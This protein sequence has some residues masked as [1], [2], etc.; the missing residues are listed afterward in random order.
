MNLQEEVIREKLNTCYSNVFEDELVDEFVREGLIDK[1]KEGQLMIDIDQEMTHLPLILDGIIK[2]IRKDKHGD[3]IVLYFLEPGDTCAISFV[4]C[5]NR[6]KSI[7]K[8]IVEKDAELILLPVNKMDEW[9]AR[10]KSWR[11]YI[12]DSYHFR[13]LEMVDS[14][15]CLA[16][17]KLDERLLKYLADKVKI[18]KN[19]DLEITHQEIA[20]DLNS[21][22]VVI[23]RVLK[24]LHNDGKI[25]STRNKIRVLNFTMN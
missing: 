17:M 18:T 19:N 5:I 1:I 24:Q 25:F 8:G 6:K 9:L 23:T 13:L 7:F 20:D 4:N 22:R 11:E 21:S 16:F 14:I 10:F 2:I 15:D 3:E 12:I